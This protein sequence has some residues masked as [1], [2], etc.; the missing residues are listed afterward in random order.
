ML[1]KVSTQLAYKLYIDKEIS[2]EEIEVFI[3]GFEILISTLCGV[4]SILLFSEVLDIRNSVVIF[5][6]NF[7]PIRMFLRGYHAKTYGSCFV[8][9]NVSIVGLIYFQKTTLLLQNEYTCLIL[10]MISGI[11]VL[12]SACNKEQRNDLSIEKQV[13]NRRL[14]IITS[15]IELCL[16]LIIGVRWNDY[17]IQVTLSM[18]LVA[19]FI[20]I[21]RFIRLT[22]R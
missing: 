13:V 9:S 3:Y 18:L 2:K 1:N 11:I 6:L 8:I 16:S 7:M 15:I 22:E 21:E 20:C 19:M 4:V 10:W 14:A 5:L 12:I 17:F